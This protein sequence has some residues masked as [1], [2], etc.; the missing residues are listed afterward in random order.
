MAE[1]E[2]CGLEISQGRL[3]KWC[4]NK[5]RNRTSNGHCK[6]NKFN[7]KE[8]GF[9]IPVPWCFKDNKRIVFSKSGC[10]DCK[11]YKSEVG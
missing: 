11:H 9:I 8:K 4:K 6:I 2:E 7:W 3:C 1:C 10:R 5:K